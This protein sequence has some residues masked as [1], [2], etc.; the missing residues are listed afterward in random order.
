MEVDRAYER[1]ARGGENIEA[2]TL[3]SIEGSIQPD[4]DVVLQFQFNDGELKSSNGVGKVVSRKFNKHKQKKSE[5]GVKTV[6]KPKETVAKYTTAGMQALISKRNDKFNE[7][8]NELLLACVAHVPPLDPVALLL[9]AT[10][11]YLPVKPDDGEGGEENGESRRVGLKDRKELLQFYQ[12]NPD[13]R[14][15]VEKLIAELTEAEDYKEQ[16][17]EGGH[18]IVDAREAVYGMYLLPVSCVLL[19]HASFSL[20]YFAITGDLDTPLSDAVLDALW[21]TK[22]I[23][24]LYAHQSTAL[25][26]LAQGHNVIVSTS[27]SS[28]KTLVY[29]LPVLKAL[30][31]DERST[32]LFVF[33]TKALA[34][35]QKRALN[36]L[37]SHC[38]GMEEVKVSLVP[39]F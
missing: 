32:A 6:V 9:E 3:A 26:L 21:A 7:A 25:N 12:R 10:D 1:V 36:E 16:I 20:S 13:Q 4:E 31:R 34:Q 8:V 24:R 18:R 35:D 17:V 27:T 23:T 33:P 14:P 22:K 39:T 38:V 5:T 37:L 28:G 19:S 11:D 2:E 30:E 15:S 29:Q